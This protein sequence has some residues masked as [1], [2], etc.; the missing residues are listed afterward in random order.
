M[1]FPNP[2]PWSDNESEELLRMNQLGI[3]IKE[4]ALVLDRKAEA[5]RSKL[6]RLMGKTRYQRRDFDMGAGR[7]SAELKKQV[8][9]LRTMIPEDTRDWQAMHFGDP[10]PCQ[11]ALG[12]RI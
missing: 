2:N 3:P 7:E 8:D 5:T 12:R 1:T 9:H 11:S 10:I 4:I 6:Q